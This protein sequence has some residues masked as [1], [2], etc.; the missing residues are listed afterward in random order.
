LHRTGRPVGGG[1][2]I[3]TLDWGQARCLPASSQLAG[4]RRRR[5]YGVSLLAQVSLRLPPREGLLDVAGRVSKCGLI[6][7][8]GRPGTGDRP[9]RAHSRQSPP[10][11]SR[12]APRP[13]IQGRPAAQPD[14][15]CGAGSPP[16]HRAGPAPS[17]WR[18][19]PAPRSCG[20]SGL[21]LLQVVAD[22]TRLSA[23]QNRLGGLDSV[24]TDHVD[25]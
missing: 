11:A 19:L 20:G 10:P 16:P 8:G 5:S 6:G 23:V 15:P 18:S 2:R 22:Y 12:R 24:T 17:E 3:L 25:E 4:H 14:P 7:F 9:L 1:G 21:L 13:T